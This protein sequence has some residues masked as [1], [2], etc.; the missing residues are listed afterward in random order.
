MSLAST[1]TIA[2]S[3]HR[4]AGAAIVDRRGQLAEALVSREFSSRPDLLERFGP[5]GRDKSLRDARYHLACLA[6]AVRLE[7]PA[8]FAEY[9]RWA[10]TVLSSRGVLADVFAYHLQC[11]REVLSL[12]LPSDLAPPAC[13]IVDH[14]I[15]ALPER[16][17]E[18]PSFIKPAQRYSRLARNYLEA[19]LRWEQVV[20][21]RLAFEASER[22]PLEELFLHV[23]QRALYEVGRLWQINRISIA[24]EH[25]CSA[26]TQMIMTQLQRHTV[27][28]DPHGGTMIA[29]GV[30][31]EQHEVGI[32]MIADVFEL[33][34]W[35]THYVGVNLPSA[36]L[37][38]TVVEREADVLCLSATL[39]YH[40]TAIE[41]LIQT[42]RKSSAGARVK[43]LVGGYAFNLDPR[44]WRK[45][46]ADGYATDLVAARVLCERLAKVRIEARS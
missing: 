8:M 23:F 19:L 32:R 40:I 37:A 6:E 16:A 11:M 2:S 31:G 27:I 9:V 38:Q 42:L 21:S 17:A 3:L 43:V 13:R 44:L 33:R 25:Y 28:R 4:A 26:A 15:A 5:S 41:E 30:A 36:A 35:R 20:A 22:V 12:A 14:A 45:V 29:A 18:P 10:T 1:H 7:S 34:G 39:S 46:G 24:Q